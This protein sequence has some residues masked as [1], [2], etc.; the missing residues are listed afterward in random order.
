[1]LDSLLYVLCLTGLGLLLDGRACSVRCSRRFHVRRGS[2]GLLRRGWVGC[3]M[4]RPR[5][6][7]GMRMRIPGVRAGLVLDSVVGLNG[8]WLLGMYRVIE[9]FPE[10]L[11]DNGDYTTWLFGCATVIGTALVVRFAMYEFFFADLPGL[12]RITGV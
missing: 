12:A 1:M 11:L 6:C 10:F 7:L 5:L 2:R 8:V 9:C 3:G 4:L